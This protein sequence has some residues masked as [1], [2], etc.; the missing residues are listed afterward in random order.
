MKILYRIFPFLLRR[1][2]AAKTKELATYEDAL[3]FWRQ[4]LKEH[5]D[6]ITAMNLGHCRYRRDELEQELIA[7]QGQAGASAAETVRRGK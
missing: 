1:R 7:L 5:P 2:I 3:P 4:Q 6:V